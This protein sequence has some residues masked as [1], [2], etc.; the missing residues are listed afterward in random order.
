M[1]AAVMYEQGKPAPYWVSRP[2][3]VEDV[4]LYGP[5]P[6]EVLALRSPQRACAI[7][8]F[9]QLPVCVREQFQR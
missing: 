2:L 8:T 6:G 3:V 4:E 5:G 9:P 7:R 1:R